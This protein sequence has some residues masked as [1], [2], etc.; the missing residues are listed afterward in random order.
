MKPN[1]VGVL[2]WDPGL[3]L[4]GWV[5]FE[6]NTATGEILVVDF[7]ELEVN[8][9]VDRAAMRA[10]VELYTKRV[11]SLAVLEDKTREIISAT[12]PDYVATEDAFYNPLRPSAYAALLTW[13]MTLARMLHRDYQKPLFK[14]PTKVAKQ[15]ISGT[16]SAMKLDVAAAIKANTSIKFKKPPAETDLTETVCDALAVG[17][18]FIVNDLQDILNGKR[19]LE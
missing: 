12:K 1:V 18:A 19:I 4:A 7:G 10:N 8:R 14:I 16:G 3:T 11:I 9:I 5:A 6:Y 13:I 15:A 2:S 17:Y